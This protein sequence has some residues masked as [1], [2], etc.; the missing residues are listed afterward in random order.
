MKVLLSPKGFIGSMLFEA[1]FEKDIMSVGS[2]K[3]L[4]E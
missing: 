1:A 3:A 4:K 2:L